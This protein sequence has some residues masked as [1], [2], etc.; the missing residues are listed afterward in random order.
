[1][2]LREMGLTSRRVGDEIVVLDL[3]KSKYLAVEGSGVLLFE[4]LQRGC[5]RDDLV[6]ALV[7]AFEVDE[8]TA[9]RDVDAFLGQLRT[10]N[11][12]A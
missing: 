8:L 1:M 10:A 11:M 9:S 5:E 4:A 7:A 3:E 6:A 12:L 2:K